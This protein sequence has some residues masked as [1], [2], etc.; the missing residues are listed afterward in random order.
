VPEGPTF[1]NLFSPLRIGGVTLKNRI[2]SSGDGARARY[3]TLVLAYGHEP[4]DDLLRER[5]GYE[6]EVPGSRRPPRAANGRGGRPG[7]L[8]VGAEL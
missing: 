5:G 1:P 3:G 6:G 8:V 2:V 7:R 4:V